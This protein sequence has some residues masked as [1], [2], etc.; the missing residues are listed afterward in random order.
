MGF[1]KIRR[2]SLVMMMMGKDVS[3]YLADQQRKSDG[4][5]ADEWSNIEDL[6]NKKL[7]H[8]LTLKI[9]SFI[10]ETNFQEQ[11]VLS[12]MYEH[13]VSDFDHKINPLSLVEFSIHVIKEM[14][15]GGKEYEECIKFAEKIQEKVK[16]HDLATILIMTTIGDTH[17]KNGKMDALKKTIQEAQEKLDLILSVTPVHGCF[18]ELSSNYYKLLG[19]HANYFRDALRYLGCIEL[20]E[21]S[22]TEQRERAFYLGLAAILG[23]DVYN[24]GE[25]LAHPVLNSLKDT[26]KNWLVD[27]LIAF[28]SG[29]ISKFESL[30]THWSSQADLLSNEIGMRQKISLL[31][32]ME[33][34]FK[35]AATDR[36]LTFLEIANET[37]LPSEEVELLVMKALA[38]G[39]VK[40]SIDQIDQKVNMT[41]VQPRVLDRKQIAGMMQRLDHWCTAVKKMEV[42]M[43]DRATEIIN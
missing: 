3:T 41:W 9:L 33:M 39:L 12:N 15:T 18:Y 19:D 20:N 2:K 22:E 14:S 31:C 25:L 38:L 42:V 29:D 8:Q 27:L 40:G 6:Y 13:F 34:T 37:K 16:N 17:F 36:Q 4:N 30:R 26:E 24:F 21:L 43:E 1:L 23:K 11:D 35:R 5:I 10:R 32:L 7:W 28:N